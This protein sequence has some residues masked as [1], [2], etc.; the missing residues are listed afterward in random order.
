M[1]DYIST[2]IAYTP[3]A[4][5]ALSIPDSVVCVA[6][7]SVRFR[8][9]ERGTRFKDCA[10]NGVSTR[11]GRGW[12]KKE[13]N[14]C[15]QTPLSFFGSCFISRTAKTENPVPL[16][17]FAPKPSGNACYAG[18]RFRRSSNLSNHPQSPETRNSFVAWSAWFIL[19]HW[20]VLENN[21]VGFSVP[22]TARFLEL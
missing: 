22:F 8:S 1:S 13:G 20:L 6:S 4:P 17:F 15:R 16:S 3:A 7:V 12:G 11:A 19:L 9:K 5:Q 14:A 2:N 10:K 21:F 18:Y